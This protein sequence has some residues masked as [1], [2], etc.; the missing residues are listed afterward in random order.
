MFRRKLLIAGLLPL[1]AIP[2]MGESCTEEKE[3]FIAV[4]L[5]TTQGF[6]ALG[7]TNEIDDTKTIDLKEDLDLENN[8]DESDFDPEDI[9]A[10]SVS[11]VYYRVTV[12]EAGREIVNGSVTIGRNGVTG[13]LSLVEGFSGSA[14]A[15]TDWIEIT[16]LLQSQAVNE[17]N[18]FMQQLLNELKGGAPV[19]N[20]EW[21]Y[22]VVGNSTPAEVSTNFQWE[23]KITFLVQAEEEVDVPEF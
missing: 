3:V 15:A 14:S 13:P 1:L 18:D 20:T 11:R 23:L 7:V 19:V 2:L 9:S 4:G 16:N 22:N 17:L 21:T 10:V 5:D 8:F 12:P 6:D